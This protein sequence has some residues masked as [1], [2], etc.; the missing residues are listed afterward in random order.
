M[1]LFLG[2]SWVSNQDQE[3]LFPCDKCKKKY[4][5]LSGL[6]SHQKYECGK[7]S[8]IPCFVLNCSYKGKSQ[9]HLKSHLL[10]KHG[11]IPQKY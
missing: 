9:R 2:L 8:D 3:K 5:Y 11:I 7:K 4:K 10:N 6:R 1:L